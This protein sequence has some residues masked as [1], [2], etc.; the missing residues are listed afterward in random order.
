MK[1][2]AVKIWL[3]VM[4]LGVAGYFGYKIRQKTVAR[5]EQAQRAEDEKQKA[6]ES[7]SQSAANSVAPIPVDLNSFTMTER[8][9][10]SM[11]L[12]DLR[13]DVWIGS[14]FYASCPYSCTQLNQRIAALHREP[15]FKDVRFVS[16]T[17]DP[18]ADTPEVLAKKA[19]S[20]GADP[21]RWLFLNGKLDDVSRLGE[22]AKVHASFRGH[23][24]KLI[25]FDRQGRIRGYFLFSDDKQIDKLREEVPKLLAEGRAQVSGVRDQ[26][27]G[28][29]NQSSEV[30][31]QGTAR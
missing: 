2:L 3:M 22:Q 15:L 20:L 10:N 1:S 23:M 13:G 6:I 27:A 8:S 9:G 16:I 28:V 30:T 17:V 18:A 4:M 26:G 5:Q 29:A 7:A 25:L 21:K 31:N 19:D 11:S 14:M 24:D 12:G